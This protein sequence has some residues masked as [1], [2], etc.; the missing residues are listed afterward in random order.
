MTN[1]NEMRAIVDEMREIER[2]ERSQRRLERFSRI[3]TAI[4][5]VAVGLWI[6]SWTVTKTARVCISDPAWCQEVA[7]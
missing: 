5:A 3:W 1:F 7:K 2:E 4:L 6:V